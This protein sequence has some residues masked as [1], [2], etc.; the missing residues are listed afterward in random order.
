MYTAHWDHLVIRGAGCDWRSHLQR[1][2]R[3]WRRRGGPAGAC[4]RVRHRSATGPVS[5]VSVRDGG[6]ER[7]PGFGYYAQHPLY[8]LRQP[9]PSTT[10]IRW[11]CSALHGTWPSQ[12]TARS[13]SEDWPRRRSSSDGGF[14]LIRGQKQVHSID[15]I[16]SASRRSACLPSHSFRRGPDERWTAA[17]K[18]AQ[19]DYTAK[20]YHQPADEWSPNSD[21][22]GVV[23]DVGLLYTLGR[24]L[25]DSR[26]WP[27]WQPGSEFK[28]IRDNGYLSEVKVGRLQA[29]P[30]WEAVAGSGA[31]P[32]CACLTSR[33]PVRR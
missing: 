1:R 20:R 33:D 3:Q 31:S 28:A 19:E 22:R 14:H 30:R 17:G 18:A 23:I 7:T 11:P 16:T 2:T 26:R 29:H 4:A 10:W 25:A 12:A 9:Q 24:D 21:L 27:Q 5:R 6:R 32:A 13:A 15:R 8:P